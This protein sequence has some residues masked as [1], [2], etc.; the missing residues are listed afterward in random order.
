MSYSLRV[1]SKSEARA[2]V[3]EL[4]EAADPFRYRLLAHDGE[5]AW[6]D[7][8][9]VTPEGEAVA[10]IS[11]TGCSEGD[12]GHD[13]V[14]RF[15]REM[16]TCK[17]ANAARWLEHTLR[18]IKTV[19]VFRVLNEVDEAPDGWEALRA[20]YA[21]CWNATSPAILQADMEGL[22]NEEGDHIV[23]QFADGVTGPWH[24][25]V[26]GPHGEWVTGVIELGDRVQRGKFLEGKL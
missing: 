10:V 7:L 23:W 16:A 24:V 8:D 4:R 18:D 21:R 1:L 13:D 2:S 12:L 3:E 11:V 15:I 22:T 25:A 17:P 26:L 19:Y 9:L 6:T 14:Q 5:V 20:V